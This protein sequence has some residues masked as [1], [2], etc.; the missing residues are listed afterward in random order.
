MTTDKPD[1]SEAIVDALS[2]WS[3]VEIQLTQL[4][5]VIAN[6][7]DV[8]DNRLNP[9][10]H[11]LFDAIISFDARRGVVDALMAE[12]GLNALDNETWTRFSAR[13]QKLYKKRHA[14]AHFVF[15]MTPVDLKAVPVR[16]DYKIIPFFT[17][18]TATQKKPLSKDQIVE[19]SQYFAE[20]TNGI[21]YWI[22]QAS[23]RRGRQID[24]PMPEP[25]IVARLRET[26]SQMLEERARKQKSSD[27]LSETEDY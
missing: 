18:G 27:P 26:A 15:S 19:R 4:F 3:S 6:M 25:P 11:T 21:N 20:M 13:L 14:L 9:K 12:E 8:R 17:I 10:A 22:E 23:Q 24:N 7:Q 16:F 1:L 5:S 2:A